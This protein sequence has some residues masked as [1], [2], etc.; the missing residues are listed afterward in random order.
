MT[1]GIDRST[2]I[3]DVPFHVFCLQVASIVFCWDLPH[4]NGINDPVQYT[5]A[6]LY[7]Y[8]YI[9]MYICII[10]IIYIYILQ[11]IIYVFH[12]PRNH[13]MLDSLSKTVG[14]L[15]TNTPKF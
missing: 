9:Y 5:H 3:L 2:L 13:I 14:L 6:Y 12:T 4:L 15:E 7:I 11:Y 10:C 8:I 1:E